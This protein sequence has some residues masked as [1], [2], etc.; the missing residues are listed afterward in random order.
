MLVTSTARPEIG[1]AEGSAAP[2]SVSSPAPPTPHRRGISSTH[3]PLQAG[4]SVR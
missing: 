3:K 1:P 2:D 4:R